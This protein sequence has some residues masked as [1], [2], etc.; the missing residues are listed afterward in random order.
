MGG[1]QEIVQGTGCKWVCS[2]TLY[3]LKPSL[4]N[5]QRNGF[6][7]VYDKEVYEWKRP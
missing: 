4:R 1:R 2:E 6:E 7:I 3:L 5:L